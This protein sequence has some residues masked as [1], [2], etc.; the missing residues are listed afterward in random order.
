MTTF[1]SCDFYDHES[2]ESE[3]VS[4][5]DPIYNTLFSFKNTVDDFYVRHLETDYLIVDIFANVKNRTLKVGTAK[6]VLSKLIEGDFT[7]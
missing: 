5:F 6:I 1:L 2:K 7:F 3:Q 4:G